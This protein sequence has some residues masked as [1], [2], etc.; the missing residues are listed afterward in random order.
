MIP[1]SL[2]FRLGQNLKQTVHCR[3]LPRRS[4]A[5]VGPSIPHEFRTADEPREQGLQAVVIAN[6]KE[7]NDNVGSD[8]R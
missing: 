5:T 2:R 8:E 1:C 3:V 4:M 7:V 6:I